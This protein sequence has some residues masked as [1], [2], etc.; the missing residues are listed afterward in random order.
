ML[1]WLALVIA[2][3]LSVLVVL[4]ADTSG[5]DLL[6]SLATAGS[7]TSVLVALYV[8]AASHSSRHGASAVLTAAALLVA[9]LGIGVYA[10]KDRPSFIALLASQRGDVLPSASNPAPASAAVRIRRDPAGRFLAHGDI[11]GSAIDVL[12][13][14]GA[15]VVMLRRSDAEKAGVDMSNLKFNTPVETANG[16]AYAAAVRLRKIS[17]GPVGADDVEALVVSAGSLNESLLG[18]SFLRRLAS[19]ELKGDFLTLRQ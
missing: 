10:L 1:P 8:A 7:V 9:A 4:P 5:T 17:I 3:L 19:Y 12:I 2:A 18:M 16:T 6:P 15:T 13:D 11:N 14:T